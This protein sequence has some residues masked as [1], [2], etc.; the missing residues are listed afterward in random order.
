MLNECAGCTTAYA[1]DLESCP[2]CGSIEV[3]GDG[4]HGNLDAPVDPGSVFTSEMTA[5]VTAEATHPP[6][7]VVDDAGNPV[8]NEDAE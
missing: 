6:G 7:T 2:H 1:I 3:T 4:R 5:T 8:P